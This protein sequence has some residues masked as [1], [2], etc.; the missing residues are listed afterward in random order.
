MAENLWERRWLTTTRGRILVLLRRT[1]RTV[2]DLA[3]ALELTD[4]AVRAHLST[5]ERDGLVQQQGMRRGSSKPALVYDLTPEAEQMFQKAYVPILRQ[6]LDTLAR[7]LPP[8]ELEAILRATGRGLAAAQTMPSGDRDHQPQR[9]VELL[10]ALGG[11]AELEA[12]EA[13]WRIDGYRCPLAELVPSHPEVCHLA[14]ALLSEV[15]G[16]AVEQQCQ[17]V[18]QPQCRFAAARARKAR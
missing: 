18:G 7:R 10:N 13:G 11:L 14:A 12:E 1:K 5:L 2:D 17:R 16:Q 3:H 15:V 8:E 6:L 4:N 9:A